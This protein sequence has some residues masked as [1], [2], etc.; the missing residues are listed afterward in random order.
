MDPAE[1]ESAIIV[2]IRLPAALAAVRLRETIDGP[3]GVPG[4]VTLLYPFAPPPSI[5]ARLIARVA[6]IIAAAPAFDARF[7]NVR[8]FEPDAGARE[9][10]VWLEPEPSRRFASLIGAL[11]REFPEYPPFGGMY[12]TVIPHVS[13]AAIDRRHADAAEA[14][15]RR[16][17]PFR[18]R[19]AAAT[20]IV[21]GVDGRWRTRRRLPLGGETPEGAVSAGPQPSSAARTSPTREIVSRSNGERK[22][23]MTSATPSASNCR[24]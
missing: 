19:V 16:W 5:D 2:P 11:T 6:T 1:R 21:E 20:L 12:D 4:H 23:H 24:R 8:R 15:A 14:E 13:L 22:I 7:R 9:G 10:V 3:L 18:R 17:L